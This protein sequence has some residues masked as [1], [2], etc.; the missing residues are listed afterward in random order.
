MDG[1]SWCRV[2]NLIMDMIKAIF[3]QAVFAVRLEASHIFHRIVTNL[4]INAYTD[5][6]SIRDAII[7]YDLV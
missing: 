7:P 4:T 6:Y 2:H 1:N 3:L 5:S